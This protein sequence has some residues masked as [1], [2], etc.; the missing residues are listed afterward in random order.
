VAASASATGSTP[1]GDEVRLEI[2]AYPEIIK[3]VEAHR[4][5][6][7]VMDA[8][9]TSCEP[10]MKEFPGLVALAKKYPGK[11]ACISLSFDYEGIGKPEEQHEK[12]HEFLR[13]QKA[14][15]E[16][17]LASEPSDD[18]YAKFKLASI[19]A[20]FVYGHDGKLVKRFDSATG[21]GKPFTYRDVETQV[22]E[23]LKSN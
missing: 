12:V 2:V 5:Q 16:N 10:C 19:P 8:W 22:A 17:L 18:L 7:V 1:A 15:L 6:I 3:R 20:V 11:V 21:G 4:G 14:V 9:S 23:L 13:S